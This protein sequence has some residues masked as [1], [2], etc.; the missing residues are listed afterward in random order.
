[1]R[2]AQFSLPGESGAGEVTLFNFGAGGGG[3]AAM[4]V[5]RW[6]GQFS[7][8]SSTASAQTARTATMEQNGLKFTLVQAQGTY[9]PGMMGDEAVPDS[10]LF[11]VVIE[12]G[13][14]GTLFVK[15]VGPRATIAAH[16]DELDRMVRSARAAKR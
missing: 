12:G 7:D 9:H 1:M 2:L 13:P 14:A 11:G 15:A 10:S 4:N 5:E 6:V 16:Q 3:S 8:E